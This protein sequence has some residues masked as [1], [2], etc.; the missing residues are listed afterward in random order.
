MRSVQI[1]VRLPVE[2]LAELDRQI[3]RRF[4][5]RADAVRAGLLE[6]LS[7]ESVAEREERHRQGWLD[8]PLDDDSAR[9]LAGDARALI[10]EEPW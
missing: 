9:A 6:I 4:A 7:S 5:T 3:P 2:L 8:H 1:A 10:A